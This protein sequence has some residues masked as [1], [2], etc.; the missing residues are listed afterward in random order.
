MTDEVPYRA[1]VKEMLDELSSIVSGLLKEKMEIDDA[2]AKEVGTAAALRLA[3]HW[4][5]VLI[6]IPRGLVI[7]EMHWTLYSEFNGH[8]VKELARKYNISEQWAYSIIKKMRALDFARRQPDLFA[9][10]AENR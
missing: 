6:Y 2:I 5:G 3:R 8:N 7:D 9:D 1:N 4:G 10:D